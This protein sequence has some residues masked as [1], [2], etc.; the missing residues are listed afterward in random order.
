MTGNGQKSVW[1]HHLGAETIH[2]GDLGCPGRYS[3]VLE[4]DFDVES[5]DPKV[6]YG[7]EIVLKFANIFKSSKSSG[8]D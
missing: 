4:R 7:A 8:N 1:E 6:G 3:G 5:Q 2:F